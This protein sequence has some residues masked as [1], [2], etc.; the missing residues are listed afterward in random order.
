MTVYGYIV[1]GN[2]KSTGEQIK[3]IANYPYED[4]IIEK[5]HSATLDSLET[6]LSK[7]NENDTLIILDLKIISKNVQ[8]LKQ[9]IELLMTYKIEL[10]SVIEQ[11]DTSQEL[12][13]YEQT[14]SVLTALT[15]N[16]KIRSAN[17]PVYQGRPTLAKDKIKQIQRMHKYERK[18]MREI[19]EVLDVSLGTVHKYIKVMK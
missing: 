13:F 8:Q 1:E 9:L 17:R 11:I 6:S 7:M 14:L 4:L 3:A 5:G 19:S 10:I 15:E 16:K 18:T 2:P 12:K